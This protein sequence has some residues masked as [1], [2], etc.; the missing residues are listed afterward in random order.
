MDTVRLT[1]A[2]HG[3]TCGGGGALAVERSLARL[4]GVLRAYVNPATEMAYVEYEEGVVEPSGLVEAVAR[5]GFRAG[6][7]QVR[8]RVPAATAAPVMAPA[9]LAALAAPAAGATS[10]ATAGWVWQSPEEDHREPEPARSCRDDESAGMASLRSAGTSEPHPTVSN[11]HPPKLGRS[12]TPALAATDQPRANL[13]LRLTLLAGSLVLILTL[14]LGLLGL[15][16]ENQAGG[17]KVH[18]VEMSA[19]GFEPGTLVLPA[20]RPLTLRLSNVENSD[21]AQGS[22]G[23]DTTHQFAVDELGIDVKLAAGQSRDVYLPALPA[24]TY[25]LYCSTC[26]KGQIGRNMRGTVIVHDGEGMS[27]SR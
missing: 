19:N 1:M 4:P 26:C 12:R 18:S 25:T 14:S 6:E 22:T 9:A 20:G 3:L 10:A 5:A 27:Q 16:S 13:A 2:V 15:G 11:L 7:V 24:G 8:F 23:A 17:E 21:G